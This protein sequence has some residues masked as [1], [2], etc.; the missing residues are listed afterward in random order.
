MVEGQRYPLG[1]R[2]TWLLAIFSIVA[3][4]VPFTAGRLPDGGKVAFGVAVAVL[5]LAGW[6][7]IRRQTALQPFRQLAFAFV[8]LAIVL[9]LNDSLPDLVRSY[10][11]HQSSSSHNPQAST[12][13]GT[14]VITVLEMLIAVVPV[15]V[16]TLATG[17]NR[18]SIYMTVGRLGAALLIG[19][20]VF[21]LC[22]VLAERLVSRNVI[23]VH[24]TLTLSRYLS[25]VPALIVT[26]L[27]NAFEEET[28]TRGLFLQK[29]LTFFSVPVAILIQAIV[30]AYAHLGTTYSAN[31]AVFTLVVV[32]P[33]GIVL[34]YLMYSSKGI[35]ASTLF[36]A[37]FDV[38]IFL[39]F[40]TYVT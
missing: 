4:A 6:L 34:G 20:V 38:F 27:A 35:V 28:L 8:V 12:A 10:V 37:G 33:L 2:G 9:A 7:W 40:L 22:L 25:L 26:A 19:A 3:G 23:P 31:A 36:H 24:G 39:S 18:Q 15:V 21:V 5:Y 14:V 13:A 17:G 32:L 11:L 16:L 1:A 29:Y 30:F